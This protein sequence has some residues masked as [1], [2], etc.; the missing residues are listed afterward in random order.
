MHPESSLTDGS[1]GKNVII[2]GVDMS[3][4]VHV[5]NKKN[6]FLIL[7]KGPAQGL[8]DTTLK[9]K[10]PYS[11][12]FSRANRKLYLSVGATGFYL[13]LL[14]KYINSMKKTLK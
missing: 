4:S 1:M 13:L 8:D 3:S 11:I 5:D 10:A 9:A 12:N 6:Y 7:G 14:Q 2:S